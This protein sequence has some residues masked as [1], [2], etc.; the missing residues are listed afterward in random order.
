MTTALQH[1]DGENYRPNKVSVKYDGRVRDLEVDEK[2]TVHV[3]NSLELEQ[4]TDKHGGFFKVNEDEEV[5]QYVLGGL[6]VDEI[7]EYV[8]TINSLERLKELRKKESD[9]KARKTAKKQIDDRIEDV[10]AQDN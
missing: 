10:K 6:S 5:A 3:S 8:S 9:N 4:L 7:G 1:E 2:G